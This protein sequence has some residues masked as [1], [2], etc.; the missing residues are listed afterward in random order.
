MGGRAAEPFDAVAAPA[1]HRPRPERLD[2]ERV[3]GEFI[4][5][6]PMALRRT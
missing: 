2:V 4:R 1:S 3:D 5:L 6:R